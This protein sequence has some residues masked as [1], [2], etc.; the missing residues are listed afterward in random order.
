MAWFKRW[1]NKM[2]NYTSSGDYPGSYGGGPRGESEAHTGA[3]IEAQ[4]I[5]PDKTL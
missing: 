5:R 2:R 4:A 1:R 3:R